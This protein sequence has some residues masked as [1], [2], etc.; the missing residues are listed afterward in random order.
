MEGRRLFRSGHI[1]IMWIRPR[2]VSYNPKNG[3]RSAVRM[4]NW[5]KPEWVAKIDDFTILVK[6]GAGKI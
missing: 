3:G 5:F 2:A 6:C 1:R 4:T